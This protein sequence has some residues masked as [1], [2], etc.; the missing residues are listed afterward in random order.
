MWIE[1]KLTKVGKVW[2]VEIPMLLIHTQGRSVK[3]ALE[4]AE[5]AVEGLVERKNFKAIVRQTNANHFLVGSEQSQFLIASVLKQQ[6][7]S[8]GL[9]IRDVAERMGFNSPTAYSRYESGETA[10]TLEKLEAVLKA[11]DDQ[12]DAVIT[13]EARHA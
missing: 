8:R 9:S 13:L 10:L 3:D 7:A 11:I 6:R 4:M 1:G 12:Q 2:A 5:D